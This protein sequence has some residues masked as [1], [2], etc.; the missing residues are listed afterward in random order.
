MQKLRLVHMP[1]L[2]ANIP[3]FTIDVGNPYE[4]WKLANVLADYDLFQFK[5][6]IKPDYCNET[7]L[8]VWDE[9]NKEWCSW[10]NIS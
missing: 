5:H 6:K 10:Q 7:Y 8:E 2:G 4:A 1:Q 9:T 3:T